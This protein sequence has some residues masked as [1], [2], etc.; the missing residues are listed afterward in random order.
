MNEKLNSLKNFIINSSSSD[1]NRSNRSGV[2][3]QLK[4]SKV[5]SES[6]GQLNTIGVKSKA[7]KKM[8]LGV[9]TPTDM[10][11]MIDSGLETMNSSEDGEAMGKAAINTSYLLNDLQNVQLKPISSKLKREPLPMRLRALPPSFWQQPNQPNISPST[12]YLP[13]LFKSEIENVTSESGMT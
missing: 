8:C 3:K 12:M 4:G 5:S 2:L 9:V 11:S 10:A 6:M 7:K 1:K 13:P